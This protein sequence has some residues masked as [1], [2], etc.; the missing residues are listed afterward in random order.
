MHRAFARATLA[1]LVAA[2]LLLCQ[3]ERISQRALLYDLDGALTGPSRQDAETVARRFLREHVREPGLT[4]E[5]ESRSSSFDGALEHLAF[6]PRVAGIRFFAASVRIHVDRQ[7]RVV[8]FDAPELPASPRDLAFPAGAR[9]VAEIALGRM[10]VP[11]RG[12]LRTGR[13]DN[14]ADGRTEIEADGLARPLVA[15]RAWFDAGGEARPSWTVYVDPGDAPP[16][17]LV[18]D[19][20]TEQVRYQRTLVQQA[21]PDGYVFPAPQTQNPDAGAYQL[22]YLSGRFSGAGPCPASIYPGSAGAGGL[23]W[24]DGVATVGNNADV[25]ADLNNDDVCDGR[26]LGTAQRFL[27]PFTNAYDATLDPNA[28]LSAAIVNAFYW[29]NVAHD[30]LYGLGFDEAS[31][32]FQQDN[33]GRG[34]WGG[35]A[36]FVDVHDSGATNNAWFSTP[37]ESV[38]PRMALGLWTGARRDTA[39]DGDVILHE[40]VHGLTNRLVGG[41][42]DSGALFVWHS[43][44]MGEGWSDVMAASFTSDPVIGEYVTRNAATGVRTVRYDQS[45]LTFGQFGVRRMAVLP[46]TTTLAGLPAVHRDGEIW[47]STLWSVREAIGQSAFEPLVVAALKLTPRRPSMLDARDAVIQ[48]AGL[49]GLNATQVCQVWQAFAARGMGAS[50]ALNPVGPGEWSDTAISVYEAFDSPTSCGGSPPS[51]GAALLSE[52]AESA[53]GWTADGLWHRTTRRAASGAWSW[54]FGQEATSN[55]DT[56]ARVSGSLTSPSISLVGQ[57]GALLEWKQFFRGEGFLRAINVS[58]GLDPYLNLDSGRVWIS[59]DGGSSWSV[60]THIAHESAGSGFVLY[61]VN[62]APY[63]GQTIRVRFEFDTFT[64]SDNAQEGWYLDD[65]AVR[66]GVGGPALQVSP[67]SLAFAGAPGQALPVQTLDVSNTGGGSMPWTAQTSGASWLAVAPG[68]GTG[69]GAVQVSVSSA[70]LAPGVYNASV[71]IDAGAAGTE[72]VPVTL[73]VTAA[74][75]VAAWAFEETAAG[76]GVTLADQTGGGRNLTTAGSGTAAAAGAAGR[77]RLLTGVTGSAATPGEAALT[78]AVFTARVWVKLRAV[79]S[80]FGVV[81]AQFGGANAKGWYL[82]VHSTGKVILMGATPPSSTPWLMSNGALQ[83]GRWHQLAVTLDRA[84]GDGKIYIDGALDR[85]GTF[86]GVTADPDAPLTFGKASWTDNYYL[87]AVLDEARI[88]PVLWSDA[89]VAADFSSFTPPAP[90]AN[91]AVAASWS[92]NSSLDDESGNSHNPTAGG[93]V[94]LAGVIGDG[95]RLNTL[96]D[97]LEIP[98]A[99]ELNPSSFTVRAWVRLPQAPAAWGDLISNYG[100]DF[101]GWRIGVTAAGEP[102]FAVASKPNQLP[103]VVAPAPLETHRWT[104]LS[105]VYDGALRRMALYVDG[106]LAAERYGT[107]MTPRAEGLLT[108]GRASWID[109][110]AVVADIDEIRI[111]PR[112]WSGAEVSSDFQS[113]P[114]Q[115]AVG[116]V[117]MWSFEETGGGSGFAMDDSA[118]GEHDI[119]HSGSGHSPHSGLSGAARFFGGWPEVATVNGGADFETDSFSFSAWVRLNHFPSSWGELFGNYDGAAAGWYAGVFNDGRLILSVAGPTS[120]PWLLSTQALTLGRWH[121]VAVTFDG[122][123]RRGRIYLDGALSASAVFPSWAVPSGTTPTLGRAPWAQTGW[124]AFSMDEARFDGVE[125]SP[126]DIAADH[127]AL[128]SA[129]NPAP[130]ADWRFDDDPSAV[131]LVDSSSGGHHASVDDPA[132]VAAGGAWQFSG[133]GGAG[134]SAHSDLGG[135]LLTF[136]ARISL[137]AL[138]PSW[139]VLYSSMTNDARGWFVGVDPSGRVILCIAGQPGSTPWLVS[140]V[141]ISAGSWT[142][143]TVTFDPVN[144][145]AAIYLDGALDSTAV[146]P[147]HT[148]QNDSPAAIARASWT[149]GRNLQVTIDR[150]RLWRKEYS[151]QEI[152]DLLGP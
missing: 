18:V 103:S 151:L 9:R 36:V 64:A 95:R 27:F 147:A 51:W 152:Q 19:A 24:T 26:A 63:A 109:A 94:E 114:A 10:R 89:G 128:A 96:A 118:G 117:A 66:G 99:A 52:G 69:D 71:E 91:T 123:S 49:Q 106:A 74:T 138:P 98:L 30:W 133:L 120:K 112:A 92:F 32:N 68:S 28:D 15:M 37:P 55:Y 42:W 124:L 8:R 2:P 125:R 25:C 121:H 144:R 41:A 110:H 148:P 82:A 59:A 72:T 60:V 136:H 126:S 78:P 38:A 108:L 39:F 97:A 29:T 11:S 17:L 35:D 13:V 65:I 47:A 21:E 3:T 107:E 53:S 130:L 77:G 139:G 20:A 149:A 132:P 43:G 31:G 57:S 100:A 104:A 102:F 14:G 116:P 93:G 61:R 33:F 111:E 34:G 90:T 141:S 6:A 122:P 85:T 145:R 119:V 56:G 143:L 80:S 86:P 84:S 75:P 46:G 7:G 76:P 50:A 1:L 23:C 150:A 54:W 140:A 115:P 127:A 134:L 70:G 83:L 129:A 40:Y 73:T 105:A 131:T 22:E 87:D 137:D 4:F 81:M 135:G 142:D 62:L 44:A 16:Q 48:A 45:P 101:A 67:A 79:P 12:P 88:D 5:L 113:F 58:N 146:F